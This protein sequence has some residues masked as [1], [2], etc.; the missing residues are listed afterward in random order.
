MAVS[1]IWGEGLEQAVATAAVARN[2]AI[3]AQEGPEWASQ[4]RE[5]IVDLLLTLGRMSKR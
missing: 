1:A 5:P 4:R 2:S 3:M